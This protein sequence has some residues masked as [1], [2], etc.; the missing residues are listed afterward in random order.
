MNGTTLKAL[1]DS[2][3]DQT[4]VHRRFVP[5][6]IISTQDTIPIC[7]VHGDEKRYSTAD[8]Y[9]KVD[10]QTYLL[11]VGVVDCLPFSAVLGRD[12]P[13][14]FDLLEFDQGRKCNAAVTRAQANKSND[15]VETLCVLPF[16]NDELETAPGKSR[17][18]AGEV[19]THCCETT[20]QS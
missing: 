14:L 6:H 16:Y 20:N 1:L 18:T 13:V 15:H 11:N 7:C 5:H 12:L 3:S 2:G 8:M 9:I 17:K 4:L 10:G 19:P